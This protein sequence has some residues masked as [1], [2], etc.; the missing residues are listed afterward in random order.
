VE[1]VMNRLAVVL[2]LAVAQSS[3]PAADAPK[4]PNIL[5]ILA[6]DLGY[7]DL[8][9]YGGEIATPNLDSLAAQGLR[10][11]QCYN[12]ARCC[13]SRASLITGQYPHAVN[14]PHMSGSLPD[15][16]MTIPEL[17]RGAGYYTAMSG[18]WHLGNPGPIACGFDEF[19]GLLTGYGSFW[20]P[21]LYTRWSRRQ[22]APPA[23]RHGGINRE[24]KPA[25]L[26]Y[27]T[28]AITDHA[29][30]LLAGAR[31]DAKPWFLYLAYNA[32]H[33][34]LH[35]P[36]DDIDKYQA[37][38]ENGWD[39]IRQQRLERM[40]KMGLI[41]QDCPLTP[42]SLIPPNPVSSKNGWADKRNPAWDSLD[43]DRQK[44]LARR[45]AIFAAMVDRMDRNIGRVLAD[46]KKNRELDNTLILFLSDNGACA[47]WDP[48][49]FDVRENIE[50]ANIATTHGHNTLHKGD[51]LAKMGQVGTYHSYGSAWAN[52]C[53]T[54][55]RLYKHY[56]HEGGIAT[57]LIVHW[58][59]GMNR[60]GEFDRRPVHIID[61]L[62]TFAQA[63]GA[64]YPKWA[65]AANDKGPELLP[66]EGQSL[67][68][69]MAGE[70]AQPRT[71]FF[72][73]EGSRA[74]REGNWKLVALGG[75]PW[76]LYDVATDRVELNDLAGK[77]PDRV[78]E[79][80]AKWDDWA[81]RVGAGPFR[82]RQPRR[83]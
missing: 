26:F 83:K 1:N 18:K 56:S 16:C 24:L 33:F 43:A 35:A 32:P 15:S 66:L 49:G 74:V 40:R 72:E 5:L 76:E 28:D 71:L 79:L 54:P 38:Y 12:S 7:S 61:V 4:K 6:D 63:A 64:T 70:K 51:D 78:R 14:F 67:L 45:M 29:L 19:F 27:S 46:L 52:A 68:G 37:V 23:G 44:D 82:A 73:H 80:A 3:A 42:R 9:C 17:L 48:N 50:R 34:P 20:N 58:P 69:A 55:W 77:H 11:A 47:E 60:K 8:G 36:K 53:N 22:D 25:P 57:P 59:A 21:D 75:K 2:L 13:P 65:P 10:F 62:P 31:K 81:K 39:A 41:G 30:D